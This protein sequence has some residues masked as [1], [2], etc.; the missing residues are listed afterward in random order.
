M[1]QLILRDVCDSDQHFYT[2]FN[3]CSIWRTNPDLIDRLSSEAQLLTNQGLSRFQGNYFEFARHYLGRLASR[4]EL[5]VQILRDTPDVAYLLDSY[6][7]DIVPILDHAPAPNPD[8]HTNLDGIVGRMYGNDNDT[9]MMVKR[10]LIRLNDQSGKTRFTNYM[11]Q[12]RRWKPSVHA[13]ICILEHFYN[14][15][16]DFVEGDKYV[17]CSKPACFCCRLYFK[18]HP[19]RPM[20]PESHQ[21]IY[22]NWRP[23]LISNFRKDD[24]FSN[25]QRDLMQKMIEAVREDVADEA[26]GRTVS[27]RWHADST[28]G[29]SSS[30]SLGA[31]LVDIIQ[32]PEV[33]MANYAV[34]DPLSSGDDFNRWPETGAAYIPMAG[35]T[36]GN[37][38]PSTETPRQTPSLTHLLEMHTAGFPSAVAGESSISMAES[39][40]DGGVVIS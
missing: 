12:Y 33:Q 22:V 9:L 35:N 29:M 10:S 15:N 6:E 2:C 19:S 4:L 40:V 17:C 25:R 1:L 36:D 20:I 8:N 18:Y 21:K 31:A 26:A 27:P 14:G 23:P 7:I 34:P 28:T 3:A 16:L 13:E 37:T 30:V 32:S 11:N 5:P 39:S 24:V 38:N